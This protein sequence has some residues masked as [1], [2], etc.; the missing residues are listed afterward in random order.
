MGRVLAGGLACATAGGLTCATAGGKR[1]D[2]GCH[3][4]LCFA[5]IQPTVKTEF[6]STLT[7]APWRNLSI[8]QQRAAT[9]SNG[10][11]RLVSV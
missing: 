2:Y 3:Y 9:G 5:Y 11:C 7:S 10:V 4:A 6:D 8:G 1:H